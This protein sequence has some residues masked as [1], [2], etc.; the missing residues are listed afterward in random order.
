[1][2]VIQS[3]R[4][5]PLSDKRRERGCRGR[6]DKCGVRQIK[7]LQSLNKGDD[8]RRTD[9]E[10]GKVSSVTKHFQKD[11]GLY[12]PIFCGLDPLLNHTLTNHFKFRLQ[13]NVGKVYHKIN[14]KEN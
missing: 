9:G 7:D 5:S 6:N 8:P 10:S 12:R 13:E 1:M 2:T 11:E 4:R 3:L 14:Q